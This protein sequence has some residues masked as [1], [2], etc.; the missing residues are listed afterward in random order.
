MNLTTYLAFAMHAMFWDGVL[1]ERAGQKWRWKRSLLICL[2]WGIVIP[3][4]IG[5]MIYN[6]SRKTRKG[7]EK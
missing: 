7:D 1:C 4:D 3:W 2:A 6:A 5:T